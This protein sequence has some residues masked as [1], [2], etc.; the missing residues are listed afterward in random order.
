M[1]ARR[2]TGVDRIDRTAVAPVF[3]VDNMVHSSSRSWAASLPEGG[4]ADVVVEVVGHQV[5]TL[6]DAVEAVAPGGCIYYYGIPDDR[7]YPFPIHLFQQ[8][9]ATL[10][11]GYTQD[12]RANLEAAD[13]YLRANPRL[14]PRYVTHKFKADEVQLAFEAAARPAVGQL[15]VVM[16]AG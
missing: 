2:V 11:A 15:K 4:R 3:G 6:Q 8:K 16:E 5:G 7:V 10:Q 1:G 14:A 12:R 9:N 13:R